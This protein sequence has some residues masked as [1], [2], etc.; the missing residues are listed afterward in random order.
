M[1]ASVSKDNKCTFSAHKSVT[2]LFIQVV[3]INAGNW[4]VKRYLSFEISSTNFNR[5]SQ[6]D[7]TRPCRYRIHH[8]PTPCIWIVSKFYRIVLSTAPFKWYI[9]LLV[10]RR[11]L[12]LK[13]QLLGYFHLFSFLCWSRISTWPQSNLPSLRLFSLPSTE[14]SQEIPNTGFELCNKHER[15]F[16][17]WFRS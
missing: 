15:L 14:L 9:C 10:S 1:A 11:N 5:R 2:S 4:D 7:Y 3:L 16:R 17:L 12:I 8:R 13:T 6:I